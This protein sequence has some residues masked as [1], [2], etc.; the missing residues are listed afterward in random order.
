MPKAHVRS[1]KG[2]ASDSASTNKSSATSWK[3]GHG[4]CGSAHWGNRGVPATG[5]IR[6]AINNAKVSLLRIGTAIAL[7]TALRR[8]ICVGLGGRSSGGSST[9]ESEGVVQPTGNPMAI[10]ISS[11]DKMRGSDPAAGPPGI[12]HNMWWSGQ[13]LM[14]EAQP[15]WAQRIFGW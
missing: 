2:V 11:G 8:R 15:D 7:P 10:S 4:S 5:T 9:N 12:G 13:T 3:Y 6:K 14:A 1:A